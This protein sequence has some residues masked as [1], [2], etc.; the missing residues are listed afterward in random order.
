M[1]LFR[2]YLGRAVYEAEPTTL[3]VEAPYRKFGAAEASIV[4][5]AVDE[6]AARHVAFVFNSSFRDEKGI[7]IEYRGPGRVVPVVILPPEPILTMS[8]PELARQVAIFPKVG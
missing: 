7:R 6:R 2:V 1:R 4:A 5:E 3:A 8:R